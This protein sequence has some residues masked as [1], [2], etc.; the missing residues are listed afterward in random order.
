MENTK[1]KLQ[2]KK[3]THSDGK[4]FYFLKNGLYRTVG[5]EDYESV[6]NRYDTIVKCYDKTYIR[7]VTAVEEIIEETLIDTTHP[8]I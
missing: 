2:I 1:Q 8:L 4:V 3:I 6:K 5:N 7:S